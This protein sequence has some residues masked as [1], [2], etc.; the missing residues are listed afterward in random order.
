MFVIAVETEWEMVEG[1]GISTVQHV[2]CLFNE[3]RRFTSIGLFSVANPLPITML[4]IHVL[5]ILLSFGKG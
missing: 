5:S 3:A 2:T 1:K 4:Y